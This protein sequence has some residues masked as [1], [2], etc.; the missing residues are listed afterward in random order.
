[1]SNYIPS[2]DFPS[3][4]S[5]DNDVLHN[6]MSRISVDRRDLGVNELPSHASTG[7]QIK[8]E[9]AQSSTS[10]E[11]PIHY[12]ND[13][14]SGDARYGDDDEPRSKL[15]EKW[16]VFCH[17]RYAV[18]I[19]D[20]TTIAVILGWWIVAIINDRPQV[21]HRWIPSTVIAWF[22]ILLILFH[23]S[24][25]IPQRPFVRVISSTWNTVLGK[26]WSMIPYRGQ[27][28]LGWTSLIVLIFGATYGLPEN[29]TS[30]RL[31]RTQSLGGLVLIYLIFALVSKNKRAIKAR[32]TILGIGFQFIIGLFVFRTGAG[33]SLFQWIALAAADLL[34]Q[35]QAPKGSYSV[36]GGA[37]FFWS[38]SF[39]NDNH[40]FFVNTLASI[41][42]FVALCIA[43]FYLG[44]LTWAIKKFAWFFHVTFGISGGE[45]V[46]AVASP[47]IGQGE[48]C[49]LVRPFVKTFT[50]S[51]FHQ[52]LTSGFATIA[53]SVFSAY[54]GLGVNGKDLIT[55]SVMSIPASIA[56]SKMVYPETQESDTAGKVVINRE[57]AEEDKA[58]DFF[59][60]LSNGAWFGLK[61]AGLIFCNVLVLVTLV[62]TVNG[63]LAYI[64]NALYIDDSNGPLTLQLIIGYILWP[65]TFLL[66]VPKEDTL[67]VSQLIAIKV[68]ANEF[69]AYTRLQGT[70]EMV[71]VKASISPRA[72][73]I[74]KFA[75][76]SFSNIASQGINIGILS[77]MAP[78]RAKEIVRL[79][80]SA[81]FTGFFVTLSSAAVAGIVADS[82]SLNS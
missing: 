47:F 78:A 6:D 50:R 73:L 64:G 54:V 77:A 43:L 67:E 2:T 44:A 42:Y 22:F 15:G 26:P 69:V 25:Y 59:H 23:N 61:V 45:A 57:E 10:N 20:F 8:S 66:G 11:K 62:T 76:A 3:A 60:A 12:E 32:T 33:F 28:A 49:V 31:E 81:L 13:I 4:R 36:G 1:M 40:Y 70:P 80:P 72:Y 24:K 9:E 79:T 27:I 17:S 63:I 71:G 55:S 37:G 82:A 41:I 7:G 39:V 19:R 52:V 56:A 29:A 35:A 18:W 21:R 74:S 51:E 68:V 34:V 5:N 38:P 75:L 30:T 46:V 58:G 48:N 65:V 16:H 53:G 14:E